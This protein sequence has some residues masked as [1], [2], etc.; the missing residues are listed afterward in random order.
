MAAGLAPEK[1]PLPVQPANC[2]SGVLICAWFWIDV[3]ASP[4]LL[5]KYPVKFY[6]LIETYP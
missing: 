6:L 5:D 1:D 2:R 3:R 4:D